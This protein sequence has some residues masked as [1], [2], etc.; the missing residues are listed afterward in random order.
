MEPSYEARQRFAAHLST[1]G[2]AETQLVLDSTGTLATLQ[3]PAA[4]WDARLPILRTE[5]TDDR[6]ADIKVTSV[7]GEGGMG[8]V[9]AAEQVALRREVAVKVLREDG[10]ARASAHLLREALVA[11]RLEHPNIVPV[12][13]LGTTPE[14]APLF[15]MRRIAGVPWSRVLR[16][17][18]SAPEFFA[19]A[20]QDALG[21]NLSIFTRV[22]EAT[23]FAHARGILHRDLKPDNVMLGA[24]GEVYLV[25]WGLAVALTDD[26]ILQPASAVTTLAGTPRY[27]A[28]EMAACQPHALDPRTDVFLLGAVLYELVTGVAPFDAPTVMDQ[29]VRAYE[30]AYAPM[31]ADVAPELSAI[32]TRA[33]ARAPAQRFASVDA[34]R[35]A[36]LDFLEHRASWTLSRAADRRAT[37]LFS[38]L[39]RPTQSDLEL[40]RVQELFTECRY[41]YRQ[42]LEAWPD[43]DEATQSLQRVIERMIDHELGRHNAQGALA[44]LPQLPRPNPALADRVERERLRAARELERLSR[45]EAFRRD[46][47]TRLGSEFRGRALIALGTFWLALSLLAYWLDQSG[48]WPFGYREAISAITLNMVLTLGSISWI[49]RQR[50]S[51]TAQRN[52]LIGAALMA[53]G[54]VSHWYWSYLLDMTLTQGLVQF[55]WW[56]SGGW[57]LMAA[58]FDWRALSTAISLGAGAIAVALWPRAQIVM[59]GL[60]AFAGFTSLG[61]LWIRDARAG[62]DDGRSSLVP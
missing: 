25:D 13:L 61:A 54:L 45:L 59:F 19:R 50:K 8:R 51:N 11:G 35:R 39:N 2:Y 12:Y 28:P 15:V 27:M 18:A 7:L 17:P 58:L 47:D 6:P 5:R 16:D 22:C 40:A 56:V 21:F 14:G 52:L 48:R 57:V 31:P 62:G 32:V 24:F 4:A 29:L 53:V 43:N 49:L 9:L 46:V 42:A 44:L 3:P 34:L 20:R 60:S 38:L 33:L 26:G 30:C 23:H 36:V 1:L 10:E 37:E 55:L 41:G